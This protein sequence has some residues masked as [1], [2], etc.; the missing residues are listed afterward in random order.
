M[1]EFLKE[2]IVFYLIVNQKQSDVILFD[3]PLN[4]LIFV[5][6]SAICVALRQSKLMIIKKLCTC[7]LTI[8]VFGV[9]RFTTDSLIKILNKIDFTEESILFFVLSNTVKRNSQKL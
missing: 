1:F 8:F 5:W 3:F 9:H 4:R 7:Q 2:L 6:H